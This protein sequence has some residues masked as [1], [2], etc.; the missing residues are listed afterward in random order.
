M[1]KLIIGVNHNNTTGSCFIG[2]E[3]Y[4]LNNPTDVTNV[5]FDI[6]VVE[7]NG[8]WSSIDKE[9]SNQYE[10]VSPNP[11][12]GTL[13]ISLENNYVKMVVFDIQ[14]KTIINVDV[15]NMDSKTVQLPPG[16]YILNLVGINEEIVTKKLIVE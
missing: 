14:G 6:T 8:G 12:K 15:T 16:Q 3:L 1:N 7:G 4:P 5:G 11:S 13:D 10:I 9:H 2:F